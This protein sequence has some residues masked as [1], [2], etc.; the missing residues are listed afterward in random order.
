MKSSQHSLRI[1]PSDFWSLLKPR[2]LD[3]NPRRKRKYTTYANSCLPTLEDKL[4]F[5]LIYLRKAMTPDVLGELFGIDQP[6]ANK[7]IHRL[8]PVLHRAL[9]ALGGLPSRE[10]SISTSTA[11]TDT[12]VE[13]PNSMRFF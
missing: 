9:A 10:T 4:L 3:G 2:R 13:D 7:W 1:F 12:S 11:S 5:I 6:V 8:L